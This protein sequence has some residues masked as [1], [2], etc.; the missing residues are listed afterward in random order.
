MSL[1]PVLG[2]L[3]ASVQSLKNHGAPEIADLIQKLTSGISKSDDVKD[4]DRKDLLENLSVVSNEVSSEPDKR[5]LGLLKASLG[6]IS[7]VLAASNELIPLVHQLH[8]NLK[9]A[10]VINW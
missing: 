10:G 6:Y 9:A 3:N 1:G 5:K 7:G 4:A 2:D 8:E